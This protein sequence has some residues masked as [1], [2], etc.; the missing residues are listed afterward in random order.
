MQDEINKILEEKNIHLWFY[1]S[2]VTICSTQL[3]LNTQTGKLFTVAK[4]INVQPEHIREITVDIVCYDSIHNPIDYIIDYKYPDMDVKRNEEFGLTY[5]I[6]VKNK[7]TRNV[8][9]ILKSAATTANDIW[10]NTDAQKFTVR[11]EQKD[12]FSVLG[13]LN[14]QFR[15]LCAVNNIDSSQLIFQPVFEDS[16]WLCSCGCLNWNDED[17]CSGCGIS[18]QWLQ[19]NVSEEKLKEQEK[20][21][22]EQNEQAKRKSEEKIRLEK[23]QQKEE[24]KKRH[25]EYEKQLK[26]QKIRKRNKKIFI[27]V[28]VLII[29]LGLGFLAYK[30]GMPYISYFQA[31]QDL[32]NADYDSAISRFTKM[33]DFL[34]S[35]ELLNQAIYNQ[36]AVLYNNKE[37]TQAATLYKSIE[38]YS[39]ANQKY[40]DTQYEIAGEYYND[41][42]YMSA[43]DIYAQIVQYL[44]SEKR[45]KTAYENIYNDAVDKLNHRKIDEAY[46]EFVYLGDYSDSKTMIKEC[47]YKYANN[48]YENMEYQNALDEYAEIKDYKDVPDILKKLKNLS[49]IISASTDPETPAVWSRSKIECPVCHKKDSAEYCFAF[50][51]D[52]KYSFEMT[53]N[54]HN[55]TIT[56]SGKYKIENNVIYSLEYPQGHAT[57]TKTANIISIEPLKTA[58]EGKNTL[59]TLTNP[60]GNTP[61]LQLYGNIISGDIILF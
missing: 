46:N 54:N 50:G 56:N 17:K 32:G 37:K 9:F 31:K 57:W 33:G 22:K 52:G 58:V 39:D 30:Y 27:I 61:K 34:D 38:N 26:Q 10:Y 43:A 20:L 55:Q 25:E 42:D 18:K 8:E 51:A 4:F 5:K 28:A 12:I 21:R 29:V 45:L 13:D 36:A 60:F 19:D 7:E 40:Y 2:P 6:P 14:A 59:L 44:D 53:C 16:H 15:D 24:F 35:K 41:K 3:I 47:H 48:Y 1:G 23:E 49:D 11:L